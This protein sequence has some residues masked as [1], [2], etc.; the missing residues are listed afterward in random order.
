[1]P[2]KKES[3]EK[4]SSSRKKKSTAA[5]AVSVTETSVT[6]N[7]ETTAAVEVAQT[8]SNVPSN[9]VETSVSSD[10]ASDA[11]VSA[12]TEES[13]DVQAKDN[14]VKTE[15][16][17]TPTPVVDTIPRYDI[18]ITSERPG[19]KPPKAAFAAMVNQLAY[20][21]FGVPVEEAVAE[22]WVEVYF[23]PGV[24][25]HEIF[26]EKAYSSPHPV[27]MEICL[28]CADKPFNCDYSKTP[29]RPLYWAIEIRGSRY[30]DILGS[31]R[32]IFQDAFNLRIETAVRDFTNLPEH[33]SIPV[34]ELPPEKK[35]HEKGLGLVGTNVEEM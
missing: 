17:E 24:A 26:I 22:K 15:N 19:Y 8:P 32:K 13:N 7:D 11:N 10:N 9:E 21:Q 29:L 27:F 2:A 3:G 35:K 1:M 12:C 16:D 18:M 20:R 5:P 23:E 31:F 34:E 28:K 4:K 14:D 33:R 30:K 25:A 6:S